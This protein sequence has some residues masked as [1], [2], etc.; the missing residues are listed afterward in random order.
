MYLLPTSFHNYV[1]FLMT[2]GKEH[3][4]RCVRR[5]ERKNDGG[6]VMTATGTGH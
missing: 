2:K 1:L 5:R 4:A 3:R 6:G